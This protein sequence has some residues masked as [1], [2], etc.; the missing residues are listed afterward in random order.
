MRPL[1]LIAAGG[2]GKRLGSIGPKALVLCAGRPLLAWC[3]DAFAQ[4]ESFRDGAGAVVVAAHASELPAFEAAVADARSCGLKVM[5]TE[6]GPSRSHSVA[7]ALRVGVSEGERADTGERVVLVHDAARIFATAELVDRLIAGLQQAGPDLAGLIPGTHVT[8]TVKLVDGRGRVRET[9]PRELLWAVQTPQAFR[10]S[11]LSDALGLNAPIAD[12]DLAAATDDASL[13]EQQGGQVAILE[14]AQANGKVT[15]PADLAAAE[16][17]L[18][19]SG[20]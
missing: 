3:L 10:L 17:E 8:D 4:S 18:S 19:R 16:L 13:I 15:T 11:A 12:D 5:V 1:A 7:A 20:A 9:P 6:G 2:E 14:W